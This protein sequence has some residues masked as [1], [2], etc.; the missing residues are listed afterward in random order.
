MMAA[1]SAP[2][3]E[4]GEQ[5]GLAAENKAAQRALRRIVC[6]AHPPFLDEP[7]EPIL[8]A[9]HV[10]DW[11]GDRWG[12]DSRARCS[13]GHA[14]S[15]PGGVRF[16][17]RTR[18]RCSALWPL[19]PRPISKSAS[20]RLTGLEGNRRDRR[21]TLVSPR[22]GGT[23]ASSKN[24][25]LVGAQQSAGVA[26]PCDVSG[27]NTYAARSYAVDPDGETSNA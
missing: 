4:P 15:P 11:L 17:L 20:M 2:R 5:P 3:S 21:G 23:S 18:R 27:L 1:R 24:C 26:G 16:A 10:I 6:Q 14:S 8:A 9:Q 7:I 19:T 22:I 25:R 12:V 13:R